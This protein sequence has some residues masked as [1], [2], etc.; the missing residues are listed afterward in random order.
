MNVLYISGILELLEGHGEVSKNDPQ[1]FVGLLE[2]DILN[3]YKRSL[4]LPE[5]LMKTPLF[6]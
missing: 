4:A 5:M 1:I 6:I 2:L 3:F